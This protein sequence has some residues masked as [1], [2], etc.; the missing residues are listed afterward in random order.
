M[1]THTQEYKFILTSGLRE[2]DNWL[3]CGKPDIGLGDLVELPTAVGERNSLPGKSAEIFRVEMK[4]RATVF[5][6]D[7][8]HQLA[9]APAMA[10]GD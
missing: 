10:V 4:S 3:A 8:H 6:A 5:Y 1:S 2:L 7:I 9:R